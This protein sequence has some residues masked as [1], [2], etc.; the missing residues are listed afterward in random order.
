[1]VNK[2]LSACL[3]KG[4]EACNIMI[5]C[6][7]FLTKAVYRFVKLSNDA[8]VQMNGLVEVD[9]PLRFVFVALTPYEAEVKDLYQLGRCFASLLNDKVRHHKWQSFENGFVDLSVKRSWWCGGEAQMSFSS[10]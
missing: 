4:S 6:L 8:S 1:M 5:G 3:A 2:Y 9:A 10:I 7:P